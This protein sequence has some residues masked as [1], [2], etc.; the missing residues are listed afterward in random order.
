[1]STAGELPVEPRS[2]QSWVEYFHENATRRSFQPSAGPTL[3]PWERR[4]IADSIA[5]FQLG[6]SSEGRHLKFLA[7]SWSRRSGDGAYGTAIDLF[8]AE[9]NRHARDLGEFMDAEGIGRLGQSLADR[10]F[11]GLRKLAGLELAIRV[12]VTAEIIAQVYYQALRDATHSRTLRGL[13]QRILEDEDPHVRF[14]SERLA[15]LRRGRAAQSLV[16][17]L[18]WVLLAGAACVVWI[19]H[20]PVLRRGGFGWVAFLREVAGFGAAAMR[21]ADPASYGWRHDDRR[22]TAAAEA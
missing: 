9:E 16:E 19:N 21:R 2:S 11:R 22:L 1:M 3:S 10:V 4:C 20:H 5:E 13:C 17:L 14:Q 8:I 15:I 18:H 6:E 12:L 7:R